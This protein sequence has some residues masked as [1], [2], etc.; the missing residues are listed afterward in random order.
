MGALIAGVAIVSTAALLIRFAMQAGAWPM[1]IAAARLC[2]AALLMWPIAAGVHGMSV[3]RAV[4]RRLDRSLFLWIGLAGLSLGAHFALWISSLDHT[5]VASSVALVTTN[6]IWVALAAWLFFGE[7]PKARIWLAIGLS[8]LASLF[9]S[10]HEFSDQASSSRLWGNFLALLGA[11]AMSGYLLAAKAVQARLP[12][13]PLLLYVAAVYSVAAM[14][15][16]LLTA[17]TGKPW[18]K[19]AEPAWPA[20]VVLAIG[21]QLLGHTLINFA[22]RKLSPTTV[23]IAILGEPVGAALLAWM[24]LGESIQPGQIAGFVLIVGAVILAR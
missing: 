2:L 17:L 3:V 10:W 22:L 19:L 24:M 16:S 1:E 21:P 13:L 8:M 6:P 9:I 18:W 14:A 20:L 7:R 11:M 23:A 4:S 5:S 12:D 15:V